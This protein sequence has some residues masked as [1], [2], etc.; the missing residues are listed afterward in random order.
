MS[1]TIAD[2]EKSHKEF[3]E[4]SIM[5][6][7]GGEETVFSRVRMRRKLIF[8]NGAGL[9]NQHGFTHTPNYMFQVYGT[10]LQ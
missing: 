6:K 1:K 5:P 3:V 2:A 4:Q 8:H 10:N 9:K 7:I